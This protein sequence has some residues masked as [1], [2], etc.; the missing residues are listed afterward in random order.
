VIR[1]ETSR[2][3]NHRI[4]IIALTAHAMRGD[5]ETCLDAGMD[6]YISKPF[7]AS[8]LL[9]KV[10]RYALSFKGEPL[11][12][13]ANLTAGPASPAQVSPVQTRVFPPSGPL[14]MPSAEAAIQFEALCHRV[15][16]D[17]DLAHALIQKAAGRLESDLV[18]M[19]QALERADLDTLK[20]L[21]HKMKGSS[22]NLSAEPLRRSCEALERAASG[23]RAALM[24]AYE[25]F[26][27]AAAAFKAAAQALAGMVKK[28]T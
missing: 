13:T 3:L 28:E 25:Q 17:R 14:E 19:A 9:T 18:E 24:S 23:D 6:D 4:P 20:K 11:V 5:L 15:L 1:A 22:A 26:Q 27:Q 12:Q 16:D 2:V 7:E 8:D 10:F 21:A